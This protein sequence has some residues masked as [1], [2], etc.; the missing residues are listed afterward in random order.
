L[1]GISEELSH[2]GF[3]VF[4]ALA[5]SEVF[6]LCEQ[7][8]GATVVIDRSVDE[9]AADEVARHHVTMKLKPQ[10]TAADVVWELS[11]PS[12]DAARQ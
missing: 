10:G 5:L 6:Y 2:A 11:G 8:P 4:E 12:P 7:Q 3:Q 9:R 1:P